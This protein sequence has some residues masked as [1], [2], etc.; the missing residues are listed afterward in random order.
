VRKRKDRYRMGKDAKL[1]TEERSIKNKKLRNLG[2]TCTLY[3][4]IAVL[5]YSSSLWRLG[6]G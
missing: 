1:R 2:C 6:T 5:E 3:T 4:C